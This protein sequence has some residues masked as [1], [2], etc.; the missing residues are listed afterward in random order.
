MTAAVI[1]ATGNSKGNA[2]HL[3]HYVMSLDWKDVQ[4]A[5][6]MQE[7]IQQTAYAKEAIMKIDQYALLVR[8]FVLP[9]Q[10]LDSATHA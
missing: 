2:L 8:N 1:M 9:V 10:E 3:I 4:A 7:M 5:L 6:N